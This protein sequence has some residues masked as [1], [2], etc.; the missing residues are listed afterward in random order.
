M[1]SKMWTAENLARF[2]HETYEALAPGFN[3]QTRERSRVSWRDLPDDNK[4]RSLMPWRLT[5][6]SI[7]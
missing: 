3:Y 2:F 6:S 5:G 4:G 7:P 1:D